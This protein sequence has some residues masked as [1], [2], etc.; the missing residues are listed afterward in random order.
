MWIFLSPDE[1]KRINRHSGRMTRLR[2]SPRMFSREKGVT[3]HG[4]P[5][6]MTPQ[7]T[8]LRSIR[9]SYAAFVSIFSLSNK[10]NGPAITG[11]YI[12]SNFLHF[13]AAF[14]PFVLHV[15][16][17]FN[18]SARCQSVRRYSPL[19]PFGAKLL[20]EW[21]ILVSTMNGRASAPA[22]VPDTG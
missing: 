10:Q 1:P 18:S 14:E 3:L 12:S 8:G 16:H 13:K 11:S 5:C 6:R 7:C 2:E 15:S 19:L 17:F 21:A 9:E 20:Q 22:P 4:R